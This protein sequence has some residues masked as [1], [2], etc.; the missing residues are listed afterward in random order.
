[1]LRNGCRTTLAGCP[2]L[3]LL[4]LLIIVGNVEIG[5]AM[6]AVAMPGV[7]ID[8]QRTV[9][10]VMSRRETLVT[11]RFDNSTCAMTYINLVTGKISHIFYTTI[12]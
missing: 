9:A 10:L 11:N 5:S 3:R 12:K 1:M 6:V 2:S 8:T 4:T 7:D